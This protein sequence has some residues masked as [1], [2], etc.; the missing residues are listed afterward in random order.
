ML[1]IKLLREKIEWVANE[2]AGRG[3]ILDV[4]LFQD[5]EAKR[6]ALQI[7]A[8]SLQN[9][10]NQRSKAIGQAKA[11]G[12]AVEPLLADVARLGDNIK[13][14]ESGLETV[15]EAL[16]AMCDTIP[17]I[18]HA[19]TPAG[20]TEDD[21]VEIRRWGEP[22]VFSFEPKDHVAL[23]EEKMDFAA[24]AKLSGARFTVLKGSMAALHRALGQFMLD[25]HTRQHGYQE[26][27]VPYIVE[28]HCLYGTGQLP[29]F[30][31]DLF[32]LAD[33]D[34]WLI[35]T[36]EVAV[37]NLVRDEILA[38]ETLP[39]KLTCHSPCFRSEAGSYGK[40][41]R[42]MLRQHQFDKVEMVQIVAP[43]NSDAALEEMVR[44]AEAVLQAL[45]L[46]YRVMALCKGDIG[47]QAAKTYDLEVWLP[48]QNRYREISSCSNTTSFQARRMH[49]RFRNPETQKTDYV[50]TLNGS[51]LA[52]GRTLIAVV[53]NYQDEKGQIRIPTVLQPYMGGLTV[54]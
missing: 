23:G 50:H 45:Q 51:G 2:L 53:E 10:R 31:E 37:T 41:M 44:H 32:A 34:A 18:P 24:G 20:K 52:V 35:P 42:G 15:Q 1:D 49:A 29:K 39:L 48:G 14:A 9:E 6:K 5:L 17:N 13:A 3:Y 47:F 7:E 21:N 33:K 46:P 54:L 12:Q 38:F 11:A 8:E 27:Y 36:S 19:T 16:Q 22:T 25:L 43:E 4:A 40:D 26:V 30:A 28:G